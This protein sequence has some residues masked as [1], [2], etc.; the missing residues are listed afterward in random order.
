MKRIYECTIQSE[1]EVSKRVYLVTRNNVSEAARA[2]LMAY[3]KD[4]NNGDRLYGIVRV[5]E[6][7]ELGRA[8]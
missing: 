5:S 6:V 7:K 1:R 4:A 3:R 8:D 2:A